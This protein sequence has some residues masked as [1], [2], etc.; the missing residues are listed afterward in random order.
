M[1]DPKYHLC[2]NCRFWYLNTGNML[3]RRRAPTRDLQCHPQWPATLPT[4]WCG[5]HELAD[6]PEIERRKAI[7]SKSALSKT[8]EGE[9]DIE[10]VD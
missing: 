4:M 2:A 9:I 5:E 6:R 10:I 3:C 7:L 1:D 8:T